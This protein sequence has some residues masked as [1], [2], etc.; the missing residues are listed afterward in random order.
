MKEPL[1]TH[2]KPNPVRMV[3]AESWPS[4]ILID[5]LQ[6]SSSNTGLAVLNHGWL[7][8][9][10][11][12]TDVKFQYWFCTSH[13]FMSLELGRRALQHSPHADGSLVLGQEE[14]Q[15]HSEDA[16]DLNANDS[17]WEL[18]LSLLEDLPPI[19]QPVTVSALITQFLNADF[20]GI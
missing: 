15:T 6:T 2:F 12:S 18:R 19:Y 4:Y 9:N 16:N 1:S 3:C 7:H 8:L 5:S 17:D 20:L 14:H 13:W 10:R 11:V